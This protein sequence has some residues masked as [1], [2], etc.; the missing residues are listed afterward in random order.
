M[1]DHDS[2]TRVDDAAELE[3]RA[4]AGDRAAIAELLE[5]YRP[6]LVGLCRGYL[7]QPQDAE[8]AAQDVATKLLTQMMVTWPSGSLRAWLYS[9]A[10]NHC[11]NMLR[12]D[13]VSPVQN[14]VLASSMHM[15]QQTGPAT[16]VARAESRLRL[17]TAMASLDPDLTEALFLRYFEALKRSEIAEILD[18][19]EASVKWRLTKARTELA[20]RLGEDGTA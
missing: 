17:Q 4:R 19:S 2:T 10:R 16:G 8:D 3:A 14:I 18:I 1:T 11:L 5:D 9:V 7:R 15:S 20:R 6:R 12:R 13:R